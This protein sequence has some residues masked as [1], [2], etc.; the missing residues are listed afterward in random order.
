M[1]CVFLSRP[2]SVL[3]CS[4]RHAYPA[5]AF[6]SCMG[7]TQNLLHM[8]DLRAYLLISCDGHFTPVSRVKNIICSTAR[9]RKNK[10]RNDHRNGNRNR[11]WLVDIYHFNYTFSHA[12]IEAHTHKHTHKH[13]HTSTHVWFAHNRND[14]NKAQEPG[15]EGRKKSSFVLETKA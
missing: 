14:D 1:P 5:Q 3:P 2:S 6:P 7:R 13:R 8:S 15:W 11:E 12:H 9:S 4:F 10:T